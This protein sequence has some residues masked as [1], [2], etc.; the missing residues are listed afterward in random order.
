MPIDRWMDKEAVVH[1]YNG[2]LLNHKKEHIWVSSKEMGETRAYY[3]D[4]SKSGREKWISY[5][6]TYIWNIEIWYW[7]TYLQGSNGDTDIENRFMDMGYR[8]EGESGMC[9]ESNME[10]YILP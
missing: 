3:T 7:W 9:G 4:W 5:I 10:T 1:V 8:E 2:I 6:N